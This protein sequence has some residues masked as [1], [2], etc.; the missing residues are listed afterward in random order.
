MSAI[1]ASAAPS[2]EPWPLQA[3]A[4]YDAFA[5]FYDEFTAHH[6]YTD[7]TA[8]L[9]RLARECGLRGRR[10]LDVACG[11]GKSFLPLLERGYTVTACD[12]SPAM[13]ERAER[14]ARGRARVLVADMRELPALGTFDLVTVLDDAVNYLLDEGELLAALHGVRRQLPPGGVIV[15]DTNTLMA[16]RSFFATTTVVQGDGRV[17]IWEG[18]ASA[19]L[20]PGG[21]AEATHSA[22][23]RRRDGTWSQ[24][25]SVH[26]QRH[27]PETTVRRA[28]EQTRLRLAARR[29]MRLDGSID[30]S[31]D[32]LANS[33]AVYIARR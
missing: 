1:T 12:I 32:E 11:T 15:F 20:E 21:L 23:E 13:I 8:T 25:T 3:R 10:L 7:W 18:R 22:L 29:G 16:Y 19:Q 30:A 6:D 33:K 17:Q 28:L 14:K 4:A 24:T 31:L 27:H 9:E 5:P 26:R 2:E